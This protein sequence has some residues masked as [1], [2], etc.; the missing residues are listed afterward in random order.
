VSEP[1]VFAPE[2]D[3]DMPDAPFRV[4]VMRLGSRAGAEELGA[5]LYEID[6]GG[7]VSPYHVH[8]ANEELLVVLSGRPLLR[9]PGGLRRL[10][11]GAT[12]AFP[13]GREGAHRVSN[14]EG[15]EAARVVIFST[16]RFPEVATH[17]STGTVLTMTTPEEGHAFPSGADAPFLDLWLQAM[18]ADAD[19]EAHGRRRT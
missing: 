2:W 16:M 5:T 17:V 18:R 12:V 19:H 10:D 13:R 11:P 8:H 15:H 14:P 7:A 9:T 6:P 4:R 1:N 3:A